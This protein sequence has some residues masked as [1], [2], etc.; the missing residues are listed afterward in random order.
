[1]DLDYDGRKARDAVW[2][3]FP[4]AEIH[5][6]PSGKTVRVYSR[7]IVDGYLTGNCKD[8]NRAWIM[9]L[10]KTQQLSTPVMVKITNLNQWIK[11]KTIERVDAKAVN[12]TAFYFS[13]GTAM[14]VE[15]GNLDLT[16]YQI[17]PNV[18]VYMQ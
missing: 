10:R 4:R 11:G 16:Y 6:H 12:G 13:D 18:P 2:K 17:D 9:A 15:A 5:R 7:H 1:M 3:V 8:E 14:W